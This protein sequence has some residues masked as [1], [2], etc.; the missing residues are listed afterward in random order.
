M[1]GGVTGPPV[2][3]AVGGGGALKVDNAN[4]EGFNANGLPNGNFGT[5]VGK[6]GHPGPSK[7][8]LPEAA[9][10]AAAAM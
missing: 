7:G 9:A 5:P 10:A 4:A 1:S 8:F 6:S 3:G 2:D